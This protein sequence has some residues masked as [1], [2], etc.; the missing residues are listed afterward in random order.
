LYI[1]SLV[2]KWKFGNKH[3]INN[4]TLQ[5]SSNICYWRLGVVWISMLRLW[6]LLISIVCIVSHYV[7]THKAHGY[8]SQL[9]VWNSYF[10]IFSSGLLIGHLT[11]EFGWSFDQISSCIEPLAN[12]PTCTLKMHRWGW[13]E[14]YV[15]CL[16]KVKPRN[17]FMNYPRSFSTRI[18]LPTSIGS[19][20][21][22]SKLLSI[23]K[24]PHIHIPT[25]NWKVSSI[26]TF[27]LEFFLWVFNLDTTNDILRCIY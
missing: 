8:T 13:C 18:N 25:K 14:E 5:L 16:I 12:E 10:E 7:S 20:Y 24:I 21:P 4:G 19:C 27:G 11:C 17:T 3:K 26:I 15:K 6:P 1:S 9:L 22:S 2:D 23:F